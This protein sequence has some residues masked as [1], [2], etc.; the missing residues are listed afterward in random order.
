MVRVEDLEEDAEVVVFVGDRL[1]P[2]QISDVLFVVFVQVAGEDHGVLEAADLDDFTL[3]HFARVARP[4]GRDPDQEEAQHQGG[5][6]GL[7]ETAASGLHKRRG[8]Y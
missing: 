4:T 3:F 1:L 6:Q 5:E 2:L 7:D 8:V